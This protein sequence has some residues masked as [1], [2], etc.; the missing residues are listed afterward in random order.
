[1]PSA[2]QDS[3]AFPPEYVFNAYLHSLT[4]TNPNLTLDATNKTLSVGPAPN[5]S[6]TVSVVSGSA[7]RFTPYIASFVGPGL[8]SAC[9]VSNFPVPSDPVEHVRIAIQ[10][11]VLTTQKVLF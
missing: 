3:N 4:L 5:Q 7:L 1:M 2:C 6:R 9:I 10:E 8:L 11:R